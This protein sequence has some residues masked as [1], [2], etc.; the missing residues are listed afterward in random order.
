MTNVTH[1][2]DEFV[3][4]FQGLAKHLFPD[5]CP[6]Q[7]L[8]S[9]WPH[10]DRTAAKWTDAINSYE[11]VIQYSLRNGLSSLQIHAMVV[12][13]R[14]MLPPSKYK[15]PF[16]TPS[17]FEKTVQAIIPRE[18]IPSS[19][20]DELISGVT[21]SEKGRSS[22]L[23][24]LYLAATY[25]CVELNLLEQRYYSFF[26]HWALQ[27]E[28][29]NDAVRLLLLLS[30]RPRYTRRLLS[31]KETTGSLS[32]LIE[33]YTGVSTQ[34]RLPFLNGE[35]EQLFQRFHKPAP[36]VALQWSDLD[37]SWKAFQLS[38][39]AGM[40]S[41]HSRSA[42]LERW[43]DAGTQRDLLKKLACVPTDLLVLQRVLPLW[44]GRDADW[45][46][47]AL[48]LERRVLPY[49]ERHFLFGSSAVKMAIGDYWIRLMQNGGDDSEIVAMVQDLLLRALLLNLSSVVAFIAYD[50]FDKSMF[51]PDPTLL[52]LLG[53]SAVSWERFCQLIV[54]YRKEGRMDVSVLDKLVDHMRR[55]LSGG[56]NLEDMCHRESVKGRLASLASRISGSDDDSHT[57][58]PELVEAIQTDWPDANQFLT[59]RS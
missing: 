4:A 57:C 18:P 23:Q 21:A 20:L 15:G 51:P 36:L 33:L 16:A 44:D 6:Y 52:Y 3:A 7:S 31:R 38:Q 12:S 26:L 54:R 14:A 35:W 48:P 41:S 50:F 22:V 1:D 27:A 47:H 49:L 40:K 55:M 9:I 29:C 58:L 28:T 56:P 32:L 2:D 13:V 30:P 24:F 8:E 37:H 39:I 42:I 59:K 5:G 11:Q 43:W 25:G 34:N 53:V 10:Y 45:F 19:A 17:Y 46:L